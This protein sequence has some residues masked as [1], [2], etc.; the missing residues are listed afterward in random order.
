M[1]ATII[2]LKCLNL[3]YLSFLRILLS[4]TLFVWGGWVVVGIFLPVLSQLTVG[5]FL[6]VL[7]QLTLG[8]FLSVLSQ[9][10]VGIFLPVVSASYFLSYSQFTCFFQLFNQCQI[11][12]CS[13]PC[14]K[15]KLDQMRF[16]LNHQEGSKPKIW[17]NN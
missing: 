5:I 9:L 1:L 3:R 2:T 11:W 12:D 6:P 15:N 4:D 16:C 17:T 14:N 10:T 13:L 7:S 8:I